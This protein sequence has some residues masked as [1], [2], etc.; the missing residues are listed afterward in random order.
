MSGSPKVICNNIWKI[1]GP[2][3]ERTD[4]YDKGERLRKVLRVPPK[5]ILRKGPGWYPT[6]YLMK[7]VI[8]E[9]HTELIVD[10]VEIDTDIPRKLFSERELQQSGR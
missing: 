6:L 9:T 10:E 5:R 4:L 2:Y 1:F 8:D 3:P 7:D